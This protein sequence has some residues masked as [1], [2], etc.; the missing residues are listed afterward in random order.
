MWFWFSLLYSSQNSCLLHWICISITEVLGRPLFKKHISQDCESCA[1]FL[2]TLACSC[3]E[4]DWAVK[5]LQD[6][7]CLLLFAKH[8]IYT[9]SGAPTRPVCSF[10]HKWVKAADV[11]ND[12]LYPV[13]QIFLY[14]YVKSSSFYSMTLTPKPSR[15]KKQIILLNW[16]WKRGFR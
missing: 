12:K 9:W 15:K 1:V 10:S 11:N 7:L 14:L 13:P 2:A 3:V 5:Y 6:P 4:A 16:I 8:L